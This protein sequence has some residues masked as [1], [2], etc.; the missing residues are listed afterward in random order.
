MLIPRS[1]STSLPI[2]LPHWKILVKVILV[3][4]FQSVVPLR[5][6]HGGL[7]LESLC[8]MTG[9]STWCPGETDANGVT[10][11]SDDSSVELSKT[12][13]FGTEGKG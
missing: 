8:G 4:G 2:N 5:R 12:F 3:S 13:A 1:I 9:S 11:R 6:A 7:L 10:K